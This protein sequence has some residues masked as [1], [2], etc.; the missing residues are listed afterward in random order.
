MRTGC[1]LVLMLLLASCG[2]APAPHAPAGHQPGAEA[3][4]LAA[5][6]RYLQAISANDFDAMAA[7]QTPDGMTYR[8]RPREGAAMEIVGQ[9][10]A[11]WVDPARA[12]GP[13]VRE[14]YWSPTVLVRGS[15]AVVCGAS[16]TRS[17]GAPI[18][19]KRS[20]AAVLFPT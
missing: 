5:M 9:P 14:R 16:N 6:D 12:G 1:V 13:P 8:A 15:I 2:S 3:D 17:E 19:M 18:S 4:V 7:M 20:T 10:N 11:Y